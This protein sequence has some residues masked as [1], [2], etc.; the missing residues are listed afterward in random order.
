V[1]DDD[2]TLVQPLPSSL[3]VSR[4]PHRDGDAVSVVMV[5]GNNG[6]R[7]LLTLDTDT[8]DYLAG[9]LASAVRSPKV[10]AQAAEILAAQG[11]SEGNAGGQP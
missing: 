5:A 8:A 6:R 4:H 3:T 7:Y 2:L 11:H 1:N 10:N 9:L